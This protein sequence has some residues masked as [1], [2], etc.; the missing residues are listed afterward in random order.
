M[1]HG[2]SKPLQRNLTTVT[3]TVQNSGWYIA[4]E[5]VQI[6]EPYLF[7]SHA[8]TG[9]IIKPQ[10]L[11]IPMAATLESM[12]TFLRNLTWIQMSLFITSIPSTPFPA[13]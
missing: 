8:T 7:Q 10:K 5:M 6:K 9:D 2:E 1:G 12:Q 3:A 4:A 13:H 11:H